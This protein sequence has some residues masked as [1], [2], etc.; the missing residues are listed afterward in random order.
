MQVFI[1]MG[2]NRL[3]ATAGVFA[4]VGSGV[5]VPTRKSICY[6]FCSRLRIPALASNT[7]PLV[8]PVS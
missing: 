6:A 3:Q 4:G 5:G 1:C 2:R 7:L 8:K